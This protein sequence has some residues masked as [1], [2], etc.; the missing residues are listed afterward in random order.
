M[1]EKKMTLTLRLYPRDALEVVSMLNKKKAISDRVY[2]KKVD[3][4]LAK[5]PVMIKVA[6][7]E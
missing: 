6:E 1:E 3:S 5:Y 4:I 7:K 2:I